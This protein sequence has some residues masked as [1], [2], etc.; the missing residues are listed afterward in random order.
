L[1]LV[2]L[3][4]KLWLKELLSELLALLNEE[5]AVLLNDLFDD[6][7]LNEVDDLLTVLTDDVYEALGLVCPVD[8]RVLEGTTLLVG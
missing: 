2:D 1:A 4:P 5:F 6:E 3:L 7:L 8:V